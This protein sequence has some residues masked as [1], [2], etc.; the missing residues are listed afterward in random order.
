MTI[1]NV[2]YWFVSRTV[3]SRGAAAFVTPRTASQP[4]VAMIGMSRDVY[5][6]SNNFPRNE[7]WGFWRNDRQNGRGGDQTVFDD[8]TERQRDSGE[9]RNGGYD[10]ETRGDYNDYYDGPDSDFGVREYQ[11][12]Y[13]RQDFG[14]NLDG[15]FE[16]Q[17]SG[18]FGR[19]SIDG[20]QGYYRDEP[21]YPYDLNDEDDSRGQPQRYKDKNDFFGG[22]QKQRYGTQEQYRPEFFDQN[23]DGDFGR[24][25]FSKGN[26]GRRRSI[27]GRQEYYRDEPRYPYDLQD[28]DDS[29]GQPRR[30]GEKNDYFGG[31]ERLR[32]EA[33]NSYDTKR[34]PRYDASQEREQEQYRPS[35]IVR[36]EP[37]GFGVVD[38]M[39]GRMISPFAGFEMMDRMMNNMMIL[40]N[41]MMDP[42]SGF[43]MMNQMMDRL[44]FEMEARM[45]QDQASI[46]GLVDDARDCIRADPAVA[47]MLGDRI[48]LGMPFAQSSS[49]A[50]INGVKRTRLDLIIPVVG[51]RGEGRV[52][53][54]A[55]QGTISLLEVDVGGRVIDVRV[56]ERMIY[57]SRN[58]GDDEII[59]ANVVDKVYR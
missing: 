53:L 27:D 33:D 37:I 10:Y 11:Q 29:W 35:E 54:L 39:A 1:Q 43:G 41:M 6:Q 19:R 26:F 18:N 56:D 51:S 9:R 58:D 45:N 31:R 24:Q 22:S 3:A 57:N 25:E 7:N 47:N 23:F 14:Q 2:L 48:V 55:E 40:N 42:F 13:R 4:E 34:L 17:E 28:E 38:R 5:S 15:D 46:E 32:F 44:S 49:S 8:T 21:R 16:R 12:Q 59:D 30:Y 50:I 36:D 52:R 20:R